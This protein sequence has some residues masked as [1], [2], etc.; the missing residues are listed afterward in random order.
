MEMTNLFNLLKEQHQFLVAFLDTIV[1]Q[2]KAIIEG[3]LK[4]LEG[5]IKTEGALLIN[6]DQYEKHMTDMI[7][8]LS[9]K[10]SLNASSG[11]LS[12]F[13]NTLKG[14]REF[15]SRNFIKL[16][17]S[18]QKLM[19]QIIKVNNQNKLL[20]EQARYFIKETV[21]ALAINNQTPIL[22]RKI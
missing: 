4:G 11:K 18:L 14:K 10:Y 19:L 6:F 3:D 5:S 17:S 13:I 15:N 2:Q 1:L 16:Q 12:D 21:S 9:E 8:E 22:D 7:R 20:V